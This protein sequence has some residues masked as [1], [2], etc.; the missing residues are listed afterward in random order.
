[1]KTYGQ[2]CPL[3][4][5]AQILCERW[6]LVLVR[7]LVAGSTRFSDLQRG[8]PLMSP[9][10]LSARLKHLVKV[11]IVQPAGVRGN[12]SYQLTQAGRELRPI[13]EM[14]GVWGHRW[15]QSR[16]KADDLDVGLLMWD[17]R[18]SIDPSI[19]PSHRVVVQFHYP[20]APRGGRKWW[21]IAKDGDVDLCLNDPGYAVDVVVTSSLRNMTAVWVCKKTLSQ[22]IRDGE[23][24]VN[25]DPALVSKL[26]NWMRTSG[27]SALG[28][29]AAPPI[30]TKELRK[31][32]L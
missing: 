17:M 32:K 30:Q 10:L 24:V 14:M 25:G 29:R 31:A 3:A 13:V 15:A 12:Q 6:T 19:F 9:T 21:L 2:F 27:L 1:M 18:R 22:A 23:V 7:E 28:A 5:A 26:Q 11:G 16:L 4:Q 20:D 8:V